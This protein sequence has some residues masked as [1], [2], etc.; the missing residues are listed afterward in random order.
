[1]ALGRLS[2]RFRFAPLCGS[3]TLKGQHEDA[4]EA[5]ARGAEMGGLAPVQSG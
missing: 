2:P 4:C 5:A 1:M 3:P